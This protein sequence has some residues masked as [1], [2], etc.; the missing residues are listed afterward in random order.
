MRIVVFAGGTGAAK[1]LRG[2]V[3][4][5][6]PAGLTVVANTGDDLDWWGLHVSPDLDTVCYELAGLLDEQ[7]GWGRAYESFNCRDAMADLGKAAWFSLGDKD[8]ATHLYRTERL[9]QGARLSEVTAELCQRLNVRSKVLPMTD[10]PVRTVVTMD[11]GDVPFQEFFVHRRHTGVVH[12][13]R[14]EG[15]ILAIPAPGVLKAIA[16]ADLI[17]M[18]P[19]NPVT[20]IGPILS[21]PGISQQMED[22]N[23]PV[24]AIS[25][26][27]GAEAFSGPAAQLMAM[28]GWPASAVGIATAYN[29]FLDVLLCD[30]ADEHLRDE[31]ERLGPRPVF[32]D[33]RISGTSAA[34]RL[35]QEVVACRP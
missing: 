16:S 31:I 27:I 7:R 8:L 17:V 6:D 21:V 33:I 32:T 30:T 18:A 10:D 1:F 29:S 9:R 11:D 14:F 3:R 34:S 15:S 22:T 35:A 2:L 24:I 26:I 12:D 20:S 5:V 23:A 19:S 28:R 4:I 25:P 13:V